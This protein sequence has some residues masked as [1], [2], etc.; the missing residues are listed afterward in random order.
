MIGG[1][2]K[3]G[4]CFLSVKQLIHQTSCK[5]ECLSG[6]MQAFTIDSQF[7]PSSKDNLEHFPVHLGADKPGREHSQ[8]QENG[9]WSQPQ[10]DSL[11][12]GSQQASVWAP[13]E[14]TFIRPTWAREAG[15]SWPGKKART[16]WCYH[17]PQRCVRDGSSGA[18]GFCGNQ[19]CL[20][21]YLGYCYCKLYLRFSI[22]NILLF[23]G[24]SSAHVNL[25]QT[26]H[27]TKPGNLHGTPSGREMSL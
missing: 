19:Q 10:E 23:K 15:Q 4:F 21:I 25:I 27:C 2:G 12:N 11:S 24:Q 7:S 16:C 14:V 1:G 26:R 18:D 6:F 8:R 3:R 5:N 22:T 17:K 20:R 9:E 13:K